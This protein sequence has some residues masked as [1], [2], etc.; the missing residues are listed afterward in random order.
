MEVYKEWAKYGQA[1]IGAA[2]IEPISSFLTSLDLD[3]LI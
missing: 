2:G 1:G 3:R